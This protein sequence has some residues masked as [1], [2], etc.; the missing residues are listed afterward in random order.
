MEL[1]HSP[2]DTSLGLS[3][4]DNTK[5]YREMVGSARIT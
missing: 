4:Q 2:A 1:R 3:A 5:E